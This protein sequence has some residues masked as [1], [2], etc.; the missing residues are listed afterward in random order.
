MGTPVFPKDRYLPEGAG[1]SQSR[2]GSPA[3]GP[4]RVVMNLGFRRYLY[5]FFGSTVMYIEG[6]KIRS[7]RVLDVLGMHRIYLG[8][9]R[10][11][12]SCRF[13]FRYGQ[14]SGIPFES[15]S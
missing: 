6:R 1:P 10:T 5:D 15:V 8:T 7:K 3:W 11:P 14:A 9:A 12:E 4:H 2:L 13:P